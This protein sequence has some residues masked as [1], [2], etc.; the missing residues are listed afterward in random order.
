MACRA[1]DLF[2]KAMEADVRTNRH[3]AA[4]TIRTLFSEDL[5]E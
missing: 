4:A 5:K 3:M 1:I 2:Y